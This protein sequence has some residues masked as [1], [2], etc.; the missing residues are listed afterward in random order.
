LGQDLGT[1]YVG[2]LAKEGERECRGKR[3]VHGVPQEEE[4]PAKK[5]RSQIEG[6][7]WLLRDPQFG[8][9]SSTRPTFGGEKGERCS[10]L[11]GREPGQGT[12]G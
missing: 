2:A 4:S 7:M 9:G 3:K 12:F 1:E 5:Q 8:G 10:E 11:A 6:K